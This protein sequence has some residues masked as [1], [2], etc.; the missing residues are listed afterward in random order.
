MG[1]DVVPPTLLELPSSDHLAE[2]VTSSLRRVGTHSQKYLHTNFLSSILDT[3]K[4]LR[5]L[6]QILSY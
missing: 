6:K 3:I 2:A 1:L 4:D 5:T